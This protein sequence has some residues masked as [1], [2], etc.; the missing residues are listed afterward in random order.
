MRILYCH[1]VSDDRGGH[2][3]LATIDIELSP[4]VR[5]YGL[6]LLRMADGKHLVFA[7]QS[8]QRRTATFSSALA[9]E[10]TAM[11]VAAYEQ[12]AA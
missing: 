6:R 8:G 10:L 11:A 2:T 1:P 9:A 4:D 3:C 7:P 12:V 5:L